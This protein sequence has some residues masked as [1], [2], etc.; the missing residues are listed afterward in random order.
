MWDN[1]N[2]NDNGNNN[3]NNNNNNNNN[4]IVSNVMVEHY[5]VIKIRA[6][7][8]IVTAPSS[9]PLIYHCLLGIQCPQ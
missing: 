5:V 1:N 6:I 9:H 7:C 3:D 8:Y 2:D 4:V